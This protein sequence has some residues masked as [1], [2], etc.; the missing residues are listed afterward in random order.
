VIIGTCTQKFMIYCH[1]V[2]LNVTDIVSIAV[3]ETLKTLV[4][5]LNCG[6]KVFSNRI[7]DAY[8]LEPQLG[9]KRKYTT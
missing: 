4:C 9:I 8:M 1:E 2:W 6:F 7:F 5:G 3:A